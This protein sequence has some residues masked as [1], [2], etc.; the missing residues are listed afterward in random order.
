M[1]ELNASEVYHIIYIV[2][3]HTHVHVR[4]HTRTHIHL[5]YTSFFSF[6][7][8]DAYKQTLSQKVILYLLYN[9]NYTVHVYSY[10]LFTLFTCTLG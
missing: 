1:A 6:Q 5:C 10:L 4:K 7:L 9:Y 2:I 8:E 3:T